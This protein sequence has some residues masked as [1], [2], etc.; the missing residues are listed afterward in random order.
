M[1][2]I[3]SRI[4]PIAKEQI[5][6]DARYGIS[7][8]KFL[9][10]NWISGRI[11]NLRFQAKIYK[12]SSQF[13]INGGNVSKLAVW[14]EYGPAVISYDRGWDMKPHDAEEEKIVDAILGYCSHVHDRQEGSA[15]S[16]GLKEKR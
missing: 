6:E 3:K 1:D 11:G 16:I 14:P 12:A 5:P 8:V 10:G 9:Q 2:T 7:Q 13:G 4:T 15:Q